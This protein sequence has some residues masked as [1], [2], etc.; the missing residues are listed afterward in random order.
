MKAGPARSIDFTR[1]Q[2]HHNVPDLSL[3]LSLSLA[4]IHNAGT[5]AI[6]GTNMNTRCRNR[7]PVQSG[8]QIYKSTKKNTE[9]RNRLIPR[10][11]S[12]ISFLISS[13]EA[14]SIRISAV[15]SVPWFSS[16]ES[17][18]NAAGVSPTAAASINPFRLG[19]EWK[20]LLPPDPYARFD[21]S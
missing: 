6:T 12:L 9:S 7:K 10:T 16:S 18:T 4:P 3:S 11:S 1:N 15:L 19:G 8:S 17:R 2:Y 13:L 21:V 5:V 20:N 14:S